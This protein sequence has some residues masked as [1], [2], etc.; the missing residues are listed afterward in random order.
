MQEDTH[1]FKG[2]SRATHPIKQDKSLLWDAHNIR[3]T[4]RDGETMLSITNERSTKPIIKFD[5]K[6]EYVG[7]VVIGKY[8]IVLTH[9]EQDTIYRINLD[10]KDKIILY[11]GDLNLN[12]DKP[13]QMI[14]DY[15]SELVQKIYWVD[16]IN[17]PRVMNIAKPELLGIKDKENYNDIYKD[18]PFDFVQELSLNENVEI[19]RAQSSVGIFPAGVIQYAFTYLHKYGQESNIF[20]ASEPLYLSYAD[21]GGNPEDRISASFKIT[22]KNID[23]KFQYIRV[24]SI[25]RTSID[26]VPTVKRVTDIDISNDTSEVS[27][28][29]NNTTGD[30]VDPTYLLYVGGKSIKANCIASKDNTLFLGGISYDRKS[31][32]DNDLKLINENSTDEEHYLQIDPPIPLSLGERSI[33]LPAQDVEYSYVNQLSKNTSTF[34]NNE[35]YRLGCRFQ[36]KSGEWSEPVWVSDYVY[37]Y[38][39]LGYDGNTLN[40]GKIV[41]TIPESLKSKLIK[42]GYKKVQALIVQ[43]SYR[44]RTVIA[45]GILC[46][47]VGN[48][49]NRVQGGGAWAQSSWLLRPWNAMSEGDGYLGA[50]PACVHNQ[51]LPFGTDR[52]VELQ[53]MAIRLNEG[54]YMTYEEM[55]SAEGRENA[56]TF[57]G[58]FVVDQ[59]IV[60]M[61][62][63]DIEFGDII[64][65]LGS[66]VNLTLHKVGEV[67]FSKN[68]GEIDIQTETPVADPDAS[69]FIKRSLSG[70]GVRSLIS[71]LFYEDSMVK[72]NNGGT[73]IDRF[74]APKLWMTHMWHRTGS[75]NN[76]CV[77]PAGV[78]TRTSVLK[79]KSITNL[80]V[81]NTTIYNGDSTISIE[82]IKPFDS[83]EVSLIRL[84]RNDNGT[85]KSAP[86]YGN[87]DT[88]IPAYC[89]YSYLCTVSD[90]LALKNPNSVFNGQVLVGGEQK[91]FSNLKIWNAVGASSFILAD[92]SKGGS[93]EGSL[94]Y[95]VDTTTTITNSSSASSGN[96]GE[97]EDT[98]GTVSDSNTTITSSG[99]KTVMVNITGKAQ[100]V[101]NILSG[102]FSGTITLTESV[103]ADDGKT[104]VPAQFSWTIN[105]ETSYYPSIIKKFGDWVGSG[106]KPMWSSV[107]P[108]FT[109][110]TATIDSAWEAG[111]GILGAEQIGETYEALKYSKD[112]IR[113]KYKSTPHAVISLHNPLTPLS[114]QGSLY[115]V[116]LRQDPGKLRYGGKTEEALRNNLWIPAGPAFN[117][118]KSKVEWVWGDTWFQRY[119]CLKTYPFTFEDINQ[120]T[121]IGSFYCETRVNIDG[122]YDRNRGST[123]FSLSPVNFNL[124]NPVY[125][126]LNNFFTSRI[127]DKDYY[128]V[129]DYP[130]QFL[131]T[132]TKIP[133]SDT[134]I[135][136]NLHMANTYDM[137]GSNGSI[138][139]IQPYNDIMLGFQDRAISQILFNSR[140]QIQASDGIPIEIANSQKVEG[141]RVYSNSIGCQDKFNIVSTAQGIYFIDNNNSTAYRFNGEINNLGLQLGNLFWFRDNFQNNKWMFKSSKEGNPGIRL[142][143]DPKYQDIYFVPS[144]TY[145]NTKRDSS[146]DSL[147]FSEQL[148]QFTSMMSYNGAVM[149]PYESKFFSLANDTDGV[150]TLW[151]NFSGDGYNNIFNVVR[152]FEF[153]FISNDNPTVTKIFDTVEMRAD[154]YD[155]G[156]LIDDD[157]STLVQSGQPLDYIRVN[158]EYQDTSW[159]NDNKLNHVR[160][161]SN[162]LRKKFRIWRALIPRKHG[163]MERIRNP[164]SKFTLG[165]S[166]PGNK[167]TILH[168]LTV[169][170]TI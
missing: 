146:H 151:K 40:L 70:D 156:I 34:K 49:G 44:D 69:G 94:P 13:A 41:G 118:D 153:S 6:D 36:H 25:I 89:P 112:G 96:T 19:E 98:S 92:K 158:N 3:L 103:T 117:L 102:K 52:D 48:V 56:E 104:V 109:S 16:G 26:S 106:T 95:I 131:W 18:S 55:I 140:V 82:D 4:T 76:D 91:T 39:S 62:S 46:P 139:A 63:P 73:S 66:E 137:D 32:Y 147:C 161:N 163:T 105:G 24:Y 130:S 110:A 97:G 142:Y 51:S 128:K 88:L 12:P 141:V 167:L 74:Y 77:R 162:T 100:A 7:H 54:K 61:H 10:T 136:T 45:Q 108:L 115:L 143:Y 123:S 59:S 58:A 21:R 75:L 133:A 50:I 43:P 72:D 81:S 134:D 9:S 148:G 79:K 83:N 119:D 155:N 166:E 2:L 120:V 122:R 124:I 15:E 11:K 57:Y 144:L 99:T 145:D 42:N 78:G 86:Y 38:S 160:F 5:G 165:C 14:A 67:A 31:I 1:V 22:I 20:Y 149:F 37:N 113:L 90:A 111:S 93:V 8:L 152:P 27:I 157:Y 65:L 85:I 154:R 71:G 68:R 121:E 87:I 138:T 53:S 168:D 170:Y 35:T 125:S 116:E 164:W 150:L 169:K 132:E 127:L 33:E 17:S 129:V 64:N 114:R 135:W 101:I 23:N 159:Y 47:T 80:K 107:T 126:Q 28:I 84:K 29:D 30:T 60:T